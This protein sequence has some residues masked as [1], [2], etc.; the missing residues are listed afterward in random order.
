[1]N[2]DSFKIINLRINEYKSDLFLLII[3]GLVSNFL[4]YA[5]SPVKSQL[6]SLLNLPSAYVIFPIPDSII[7][8]SIWIILFLIIRSIPV[9]LNTFLSSIFKNTYQFDSSNKEE[10]MTSD[11]FIKEWILQGSAIVY[12]GA[13]LVS[14]SNSG[15]LIK[16]KWFRK[17][18]KD[19]TATIEVSFP[20]QQ[21]SRFERR[22]GVIFRAQNHE[23]YL[24]LEFYLD[25]DDQL[26]FRPHVRYRGNWDAPYLDIDLNMHKVTTSDIE[27]IVKVKNNLV[28]V[29]VNND[30]NIF[31][32]IIPTHIEVNLVQ[33]TQTDTLSKTTVPELYFRNNA[34]MFGFRTYGNQFALIK[35]LSIQQ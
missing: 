21:D 19:F 14:N 2:L 12:K 24:M 35:S 16:N 10:S 33:K 29:D 9:K 25:K 15:C 23:D 22:I 11:K 20:K 7:Q 6:F 3:S 1:M 26:K 31:T 5:F 4:L 32:W 17:S 18:W 30:K 27:L 13:I 28:T 34:G 8:I